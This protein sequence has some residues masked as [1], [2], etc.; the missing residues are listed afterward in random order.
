VSRGSRGH[1]RV[2]TPPR[3][4]HPTAA[5]P[6]LP[7]NLHRGTSRGRG[8]RA[9]TKQYKGIASLPSVVEHDESEQDS[10][11]IDDDSELKT[12]TDRSAASE[13]R[14]AA[15]GNGTGFET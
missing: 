9:S 11:R 14:P 13:S 12:D 15:G 1:H 5:V 8:S 7:R 10:L 4:A 6:A 3:P 2:E